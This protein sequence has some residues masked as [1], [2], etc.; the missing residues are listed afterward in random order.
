MR[1]V[2]PPGVSRSTATPQ[3]DPGEQSSSSDTCGRCVPRICPTLRGTNSPSV[4]RI[5]K[6]RLTSGGPRRY[7]FQSNVERI[8]VFHSTPGYSIETL[9]TLR[10]SIIQR[11]V[12][13]GLQDKPRLAPTGNEWM[14]NLPR[15][16]RRESLKRIAG[17]QTGLTPGEG[18]RRTANRTSL[19][20]R[21]ER[22][23]WPF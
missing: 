11:A 21:R 16:W 13:R 3:L 8:P 19:P 2:L 7:A 9:D 17:I 6:P 15:G 18:I 10:K 12:T 22:P 5:N 20:A 4:K 1:K 23:G 14:E